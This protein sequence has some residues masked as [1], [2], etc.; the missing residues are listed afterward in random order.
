MHKN[1]MEENVFVKKLINNIVAIIR[2]DPLTKDDIKRFRAGK[3]LRIIKQSIYTEY[4]ISVFFRTMKVLETLDDMRA[5]QVFLKQYPYSKILRSKGISRGSFMIYHIEV[6]LFK[7]ATLKDKLALLINDVYE[8]GLPDRRVN[9]DLIS[10]M[11]HMKGN[12]AISKLKRFRKALDGI[13]RERNVIAHKG[14][15]EDKEMDQIRMYELVEEDMEEAANA[16]KE[17]AKIYV[18]KRIGILKENQLVI[19]RFL[20]DFFQALNKDYKAKCKLFNLLRKE[21]IKTIGS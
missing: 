20:N 18:N 16:V 11:K 15:Y 5:A 2:E 21:H 1:N 12:L 10:E 6:Y 19:E 14:K 13:S 17:M 4:N 8:L 7:A 9:I 3:P